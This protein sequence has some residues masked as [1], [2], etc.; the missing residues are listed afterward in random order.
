MWQFC[1]IWL[2]RARTRGEPPSINLLTDCTRP[3]A[4]GAVPIGEISPS[5]AS[6]H[7]VKDSH[8][9]QIASAPEELWEPLVKKA[10]EE[11]W[12]VKETAAQVQQ[13]NA[14]RAA[15]Q[16]RNQRKARVRQDGAGR[17]VGMGMGSGAT[18]E[19][20]ASW[21]RSACARRSRRT[22]NSSACWRARS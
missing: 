12:T 19:A 10:E 8:L 3:H 22:P 21:A 16:D 5:G 2:P 1:H 18:G 14:V 11:K 13:A 20:G 15:P 9:M 6:P 7:H 4:R 17:A